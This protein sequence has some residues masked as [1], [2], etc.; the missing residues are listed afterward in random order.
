MDTTI[1][2]RGPYETGGTSHE[3]REAFLHHKKLAKPAHFREVR[4][5]GIYGVFI[6]LR[7]AALGE[8][9]RRPP[10]G[11][12]DPLDVGVGLGVERDEFEFAVGLPLYDASGFEIDLR[13]YFI[14][15]RTGRDGLKPAA[16]LLDKLAAEG[17][18]TI[19]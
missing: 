18:L 6:N 15:R 10:L 9:R 4:H 2:T 16:E 13:R 5:Q 12:K 14:L 8:T 19:Y 7:F 17:L 3:L 1:I 11:P